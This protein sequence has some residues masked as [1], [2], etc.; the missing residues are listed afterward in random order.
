MNARAELQ[1]IIARL[2]VISHVPA[3]NQS[4]KAEVGG[5]TTGDEKNPGG[6]RPRGGIDHQDDKDRDSHVVKSADHYRRRLA[7]CRTT[8]DVE[9]VRDCARETLR[10]WTHTPP[11]G[12]EPKP[13]EPLFMR[14]LAAQ[15]GSVDTIS[16]Q[17]GV[18]RA[19]VYKARDRHPQDHERAV[20]AA[21]KGSVRRVA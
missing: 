8:R 3:L 1:A 15:T 7:R 21:L 14:W 11:A 2:E 10:T 6:H 19:L 12:P 4:P 16:R 13:G 5:A 9:L 17:A 18:S 20:D